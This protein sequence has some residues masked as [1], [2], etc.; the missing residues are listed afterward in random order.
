MNAL[1]LAVAPLTE[2]LPETPFS[3]ALAQGDEH[4][5]A[6]DAMGALECYLTALTAEDAE[7]TSPLL[8]PDTVDQI[9]AQV[10]IA[11]VFLTMGADEQ[12]RSCLGRADALANRAAWIPSVTP[13]EIR[14]DP[15]IAAEWSRW[16]RITRCEG[17]D[18][19]ELERFAD[20]LRRWGDVYMQRG[21][22]HFGRALAFWVLGAHLHERR[23]PAEELVA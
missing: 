19:G 15:E 6:D 21:T 1:E 12:A 3:C 13:L 4:L 17:L 11:T 7:E 5:A 18:E 2:A 20:L 23:C 10:R 22:G 8:G 14:L 16:E 9:R